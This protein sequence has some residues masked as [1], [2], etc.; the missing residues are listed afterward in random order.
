MTLSSVGWVGISSS[1]CGSSTDPAAHGEDRVRRPKGSPKNSDRSARCR[2]EWIS[3]L[4]RG[5]RRAYRGRTC[6]RRRC[7]MVRSA[8]PVSC[9]GVLLL[10]SV[11]GNARGDTIVP[12]SGIGTDLTSSGFTIATHVDAVTYSDPVVVEVPAY[13]SAYEIRGTVSGV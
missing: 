8:V 5:L 9:F 7:P 4:E 13:G 1:A 2:T 10:L 11:A 3:W 12:I 6:R